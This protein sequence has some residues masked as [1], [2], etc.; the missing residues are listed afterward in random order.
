MLNP[1]KVVTLEKRLLAATAKLEASASAE[2]RLS[3]EDDIKKIKAE[4]VGGCG[5]CGGWVWGV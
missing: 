2:E 5:V 4:L 1:I 3:T